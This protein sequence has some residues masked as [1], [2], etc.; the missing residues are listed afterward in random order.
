MIFLILSEN[1]E[2]NALNALTKSLELTKGNLVKLFCFHCR[3][4]GWL[5]LSILTLGI[6]FFWLLPYYYSSV[7]HF[8]LDLKGNEN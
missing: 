6:G 4:I 1:P 8:Y 2:M 5:I 3:F 7:S